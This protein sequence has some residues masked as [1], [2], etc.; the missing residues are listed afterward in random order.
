MGMEWFVAICGFL[1]KYT[2]F[3]INIR[4][5]KQG[6]KPVEKNVFAGGFQEKSSE[7]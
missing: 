4:K 3:S 5:E 6:K 1:Q 2:P 7:A